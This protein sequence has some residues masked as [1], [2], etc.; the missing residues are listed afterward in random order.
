MSGTSYLVTGATGNIGARVVER[1]LR[2]G[3]R[4]RLFVRDAGKA[5]TR[6]G[7]RVDL[8]VGDLADAASLARALRGVDALFL[9]N[10]GPGLEVRDEAAARVARASG[11]KR[12]VKLSSLDAR[13]QV[14][15]G[16]WHARGETA[17]RATGI[18]FV[19]VQ[20][21]GFMDNAL[22]W[23]RG[24]KS[25]GVV[26]SPTGDGRIAFIHSDDVADVA[27]KALTTSEYEG[28]ELPI[29]GPE[30]LSYGDMTARIAAAIEKSLRY[31]SMSEADVARLQ[32]TLG[33]PP[34]M[35]EAHLSI[36]RAIRE[37][38]LATVT[39]VVKRVLARPAIGFDRWVREHVDSFRS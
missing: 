9:V 5:A 27:T 8:A 39:D 32:I 11:V 30:A 7:D 18:A 23:A 34:A 21:T 35:V 29:T 22:F 20:P 28:Q 17:I 4:P 2:R 3:E 15:T 38:R 14:G 33:E 37:G 1:L 31:E 12:L 10:S 26:R 25:E 19:F 6:F 36:Y 24:I 16:I 13:Q